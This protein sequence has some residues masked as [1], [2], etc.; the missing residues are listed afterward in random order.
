MASAGRERHKLDVEWKKRLGKMEWQ[1]VVL[2][3]IADTHGLG[4]GHLGPAR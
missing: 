2:W 3:Y 1:E 4:R